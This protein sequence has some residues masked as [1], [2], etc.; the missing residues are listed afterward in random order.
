MDTSNQFTASKTAASL[1]PASIGTDQQSAGLH[2]RGTAAGRSL[3]TVSPQ[4]SVISD[5]PVQE[6]TGTIT[7]IEVNPSIPPDLRWLFFPAIPEATT[8]HNGS[9]AHSASGGEPLISNP[10]SINDTEQAERE[11]ADLL[12][13]FYRNPSEAKFRQFEKLADLN[14]DHLDPGKACLKHKLPFAIAL[15]SEKKQLAN[16]IN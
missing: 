2:K 9:S 10:A 6:I 13:N 8:G 11:L 1:N 4:A 5:T 14:F 3:E 15:I 16:S 12:T 7:A